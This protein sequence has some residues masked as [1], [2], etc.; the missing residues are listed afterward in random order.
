MKILVT[1]AAL[2][3]AFA[4]PCAVQAQTAAAPAHAE[5]LAVVYADLDLS[6]PAATPT[7]S[8]P[9]TA[10]A[11]GASETPC[12]TAGTRSPRTARSDPPKAAPS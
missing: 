12:R 5:T 6:Q 11:T 3:L 9:P 1:G 4:L 7:W 10:P 2:V 8:W